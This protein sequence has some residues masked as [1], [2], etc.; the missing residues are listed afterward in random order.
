MKKRRGFFKKK[1]RSAFRGVSRYARRGTKSNRAQLVQLDAMLYGA[2]RGPVSDKTQQLLGGMLG[3][4]PGSIGDE[5]SMGLIDWLVAK[6]TSGMVRD[7]A[8]KGLVVENARLGEALAQ[9]GLGLLGA[10]STTTAKSGHVYG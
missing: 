5:V 3:G 8:V 10:G 4:I 7:I 2:I 9:G 1:A 6:N